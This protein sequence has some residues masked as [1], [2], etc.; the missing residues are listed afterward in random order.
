MAPKKNPT[1][2]ATMYSKYTNTFAV[3]AKIKP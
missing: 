2:T 3:Q 1:Q